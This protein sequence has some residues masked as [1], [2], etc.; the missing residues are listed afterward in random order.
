MSSAHRCIDHVQVD[1]LLVSSGGGVCRAQVA[2]DV[3]VGHWHLGQVRQSAQAKRC[4]AALEEEFCH[5]QKQGCARGVRGLF[6][7]VDL[8]AVGIAG[9]AQPVLPAARLCVQP[10]ALARVTREAARV[11]LSKTSHPLAFPP[12]TAGRSSPSMS[13]ANPVT[14]WPSCR[15]N[16]NSPSRMRTFGLRRASP[17]RVLAARPAMATST[18]TRISSMGNCP[19]G[20]AMRAAGSGCSPVPVCIGCA[21]AGKAAMAAGSGASAMRR[22]RKSRRSED[23]GTKSVPLCWF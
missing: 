17:M 12:G 14:L 2:Q 15:G 22:K 5:T 23:D 13:N 11:V 16:C 19:A 18:C 3:P 20:I 9:R 21:P 8:V 7:Q 6:V 1:G 4:V 10:S